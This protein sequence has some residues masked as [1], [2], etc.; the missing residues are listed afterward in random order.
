MR[1]TCYILDSVGPARAKFILSCHKGIYSNSDINIHDDFFLLL[2]VL[3]QRNPHNDN[4]NVDNN[5]IMTNLI[6]RTHLAPEKSHSTV[7]SEAR[8]MQL[9][10]L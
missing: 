4:S 2:H 5:D 7:H 1:R 6:Y 3:H 10:S 8:C 9:F